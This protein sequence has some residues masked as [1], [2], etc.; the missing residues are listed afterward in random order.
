MAAY[1]AGD[2]AFSDAWYN[3][4]V[5]RKCRDLGTNNPCEMTQMTIGEADTHDP[6]DAYDSASGDVISNVYDTRETVMVVRLSYHDWLPD[7]LLVKT[8]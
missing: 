7:T 3:L 1:A 5:S 6:A 2:M 8:V 4:S